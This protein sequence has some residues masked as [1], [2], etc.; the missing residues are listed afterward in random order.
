MQTG[1]SFAG[2]GEWI[3][4]KAILLSEKC[5]CVVR[6][7]DR[8]RLFHERGVKD[9][10]RL[11][12]NEP[13]SLEGASLADKVVGKAAAALMIAGGV[14]EVYAVIVSQPACELFE[15][16]PVRLR[17]GS[18][19]PHIINRTQT[20]W[21]PLEKRCRDAVDVQDCLSRIESFLQS[22]D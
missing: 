5:S 9:L 3:D 1:E 4:L 21:C 15:C 16:S 11:L 10:Y 18:V 8:I 6:K 20:D 2:T 17:F 19:V 13:G 22:V 7:G 14:K 12:R